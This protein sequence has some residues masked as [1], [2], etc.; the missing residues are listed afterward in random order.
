M[1]IRGTLLSMLAIIMIP[2]LASSTYLH[3]SAKQYIL[4]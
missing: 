4:R 2:L 3:K 1:N